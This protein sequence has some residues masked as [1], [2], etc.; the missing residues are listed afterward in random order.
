MFVLCS[1]TGIEDLTNGL[2]S[3]RELSSSYIPSR[4]PSFQTSSAANPLTTAPRVL[5]LEFEVGKATTVTGTR[6]SAETRFAKELKEGNVI[7]GVAGT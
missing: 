6:P 1:I 3:T 7:S 5:K 2:L 4:K